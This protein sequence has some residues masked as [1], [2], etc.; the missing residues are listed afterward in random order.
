MQPIPH[1]AAASSDAHYARSIAAGNV[2]H[3]SH[4]LSPEDTAFVLG[5]CEERGV[6][7]S[8]AVDEALVNWASA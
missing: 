1:R 3:I 2:L 5:A 6:S 8:T 4:T 7:L